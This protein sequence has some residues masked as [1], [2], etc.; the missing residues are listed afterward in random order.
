MGEGVSL[1]AGV[2]TARLYYD[3][4]EDQVSAFGVT[5]KEGHYKT[6]LCNYAALFKGIH[7]RECQFYLL[8]DVEYLRVEVQD[9]GAESLKIQGAEI[10][11]AFRWRADAG[12]AEQEEAGFDREAACDIW[13]S[14]TGTDVF[15]PDNGR[16]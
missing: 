2:Y 8:D 15:S 10:Q 3:T 7:V 4:G 16:L 1:P 9:N 14:R 5:V 12:N 13:C 6:L 11:P